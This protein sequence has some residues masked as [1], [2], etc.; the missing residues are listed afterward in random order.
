MSDETSAVVSPS[1]DPI[2]IKLWA[3]GLISILTFL[4]G[5]P[6]SM[7]LASINWLRMERKQKAITH[8]ILCG[9]GMITVVLMGISQPAG[10]FRLYSFLLNI[11]MLMYLY[12]E[13]RTD[14]SKLKAAGYIVE[15]A[16]WVG[17]LFICMGMMLA[18]YLMVVLVVLIFAILDIPINDTGW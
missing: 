9:L 4:F 2:H 12:N 14:I 10:S 17:G 18:R 15:N 3:P 7:L 13:T 6:G 11:G 16:S 8:F 5:F 1:S